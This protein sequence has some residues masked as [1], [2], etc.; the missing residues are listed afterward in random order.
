MTDQAN[1]LAGL[2]DAFDAERERIE[3]QMY[4]TDAEGIR[5]Y[6][7]RFG[8]EAAAERYG[9]GNVRAAWIPED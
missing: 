9:E 4:G 5:Q 7:Q 3:M 6:H 1:S 8:F 2:I